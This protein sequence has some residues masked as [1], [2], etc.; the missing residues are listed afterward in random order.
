MYHS[1]KGIELNST[2]NSAWM[3]LY[4]MDEKL[5]LGQGFSS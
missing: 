5:I 1:H 3:L 4:C 2:D